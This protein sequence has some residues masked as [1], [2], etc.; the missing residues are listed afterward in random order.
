[1]TA[2]RLQKPSDVCQVNLRPVVWP[3]DGIRW[4]LFTGNWSGPRIGA[5]F[6]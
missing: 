3:G 5:E 2:A 6:D 1:M 4:T